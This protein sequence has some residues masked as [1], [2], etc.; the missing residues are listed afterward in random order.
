IRFLRFIVLVFFGFKQGF[1]LFHVV[2]VGGDV[3]QCLGDSLARMV[4]VALVGPVDLAD[5]FELIAAGG[6]KEIIGGHNASAHDT[7]HSFLGKDHIAGLH[8]MDKLPGG[9]GGIFIGEGR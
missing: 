3:C 9:M 8:I 1:Q 2:G 4:P 7:V 6:V 5:V